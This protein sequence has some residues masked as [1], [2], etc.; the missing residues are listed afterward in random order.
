MRILPITATVLIWTAFPAHAASGDACALLAAQQVSTVLGVQVD[1]GVAR[2]PG[3]PEFC[4]WGEHGKDES[5]ARNVRISLTDERHFELQK[6]MRGPKYQLTPESG[7]GDEAYWLHGP[8]LDRSLNVKEGGTVFRV[9]ARPISG[10][11]HKKGSDAGEQALD[12]KYKAAEL[13]IA[14]YVLHKL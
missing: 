5:V 14:K 13:Q 12:D 10:L 6:T 2:L 8:G 11:L 1:A 3:H 4:I 7:I 9:E